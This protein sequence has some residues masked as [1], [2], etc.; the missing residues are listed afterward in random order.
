MSIPENLNN[1]LKELPVNTKLVAITKNKTEDKIMEAYNA[2][3]RVFGENRMQELVK[4]YEN[5]PKDIEWH[6]VGH[7]QTN[8]VKYIAPFVSLIHSVDSKKLLAV[9]NKEALRNNRTIACL[10]QL[11]IAKEETKFG[12]TFKEI[13]DIIASE[14]FKDFK[15]VTVNG[16]MGMATFTDDRELV[17]SEFRYLAECF[18]ELKSSFFKSSEHFKELSM[19]MSDDYKLALEQGATIVRIGS[20]IFGMKLS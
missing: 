17:I 16:L 7:L 10:F 19:G 20:R 18:E 1:I 11:R 4:K 3:H 8:K 14:D 12:I 15:N 9:I 13:T 6:M 5:L 2:G